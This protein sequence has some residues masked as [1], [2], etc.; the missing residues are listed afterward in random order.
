MLN[1]SVDNNEEL[2]AKLE[3]TVI[4][5]NYRENYRRALSQAYLI[6]AWNEANKPEQE[7]NIQLLQA[8]AAGSIQQARLATSLSPNSVAAWEN[9]GIIYRDARGLVGG[10]LPF[11]LEA[12]AKASELEPN[13]PFLSAVGLT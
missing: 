11:A 3:R 9:L 7:Q 1:L 4:L 13:N 5:N 8:L 6:S 12:F 2:V 10:T